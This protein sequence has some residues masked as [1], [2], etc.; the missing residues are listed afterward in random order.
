[1]MIGGAIVNGL[2]FSGSGYL[3]K[4]IDRNGY[5]AEMKR[6]NLAQEKLQKATAEWGEHRKKIIDYANL[7]LKKET[8]LL[9][10]SPTLI[11]L[12][13]YTMNSTQQ[14]N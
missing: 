8:K 1:M 4:A 14:I 12:Y 6:H 5:E 11:M 3:F 10:I 9:L 2:A 13:F 7:H